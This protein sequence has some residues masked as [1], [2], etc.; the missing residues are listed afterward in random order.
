MGSS[1]AKSLRQIVQ[2]IKYRKRRFKEILQPRLGWLC[3]HHPR[4]LQLPSSYSSQIKLAAT[5]KISIVT[6]SYE[7]VSYIEKTLHSVIDQHYPNIEYFVQDGGSKDGSVEI[8]KKYETKLSGWESKSDGG[9]A[10][11]VN[12]GFA[13]SSGEI[14]AWLNSDDLLLPGALAFIANYFEAHPEVDVVYGNRILIDE[15]DMQIG[16]WLMPEH[17]N[18]VLSW[19]D[20]IPQ[21][22]LFWRRRIWDKIGG[23]LDESFS[24]A[25]DWDLLIRFRDAGAKFARLPRFLAAFRV[26]PN[27]KTSA[28][29]SKVGYIE[30]GLLR[31]RTLGYVPTHNEIKRAVFP[32]LLRHIVTDLKWRILRKLGKEY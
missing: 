17:D 21:E 6:P 1:L 32:Y 10:A 12:V 25:M 3:Q 30:M 16:R 18:E 26:H 31:K 19:V 29:I 9:Q 7:Q 5:P 24:F 8:I 22:T 2:K 23:Q 13:K 4:H 14:M 11:A 27:Q 28:A 20:Y 15:N